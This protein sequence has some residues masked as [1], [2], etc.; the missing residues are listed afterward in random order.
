MRDKTFAVYWSETLWGEKFTKNRILVFYTSFT[1]SIVVYWNPWKQQKFSPFNVLSLMVYQLIKIMLYTTSLYSTL[2]SASSIYAT[3][4]VNDECFSRITNL[5]WT[6]HI[7]QVICLPNVL[8]T[9]VEESVTSSVMI[10]PLL[11]RKLRQQ[12]KPSLSILGDQSWTSHLSTS[13]KCRILF[14]LVSISE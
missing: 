14:P 3:H 11:I 10:K 4:H 9:E 7:T 6:W 12:I 2:F 13:S 1:N 5:Q 8:A